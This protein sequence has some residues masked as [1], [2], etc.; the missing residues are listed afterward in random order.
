MTEQAASIAYEDN[1]RLYL[2]SENVCHTNKGYILCDGQSAVL[3]PSLTFD[4]NGWYL[5][6]L[7]SDDDFQLICS[8][9]R[10]G[11]V[12]WYSQTRRIHCPVCGSLGS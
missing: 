7:S 12:W 9:P 10:C 3:L 6:G 2:K 4:A 1:G 11:Y 5:D 8:N